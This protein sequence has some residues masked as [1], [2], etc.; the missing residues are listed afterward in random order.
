MERITNHSSPQRGGWW[1]AVVVCGKPPGTSTGR[2]SRPVYFR[3]TSSRRGRYRTGIL[4][5][6]IGGTGDCRRLPVQSAGDPHEQPIRIVRAR[7]QRC[8][9]PCPKSGRGRGNV[10]RVAP[11]QNLARPEVRG[12]FSPLSPQAAVWIGPARVAL[13]PDRALR[14]W[15]LET[16]ARPLLCPTGE[17]ASRAVTHAQA[18]HRP[19]RAQTQGFELAR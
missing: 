12:R 9:A 7:G 17:G 2:G 19:P 10:D 18:A 16:S 8:G 3:A 6:A 11:H 15:P 5:S 1:V 14:H 13:R 4:W